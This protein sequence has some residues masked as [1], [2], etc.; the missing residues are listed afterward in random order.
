[1]SLERKSEISHRGRAIRDL[2]NK[3]D[4]FSK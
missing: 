4:K 3:I 1:M 2:K